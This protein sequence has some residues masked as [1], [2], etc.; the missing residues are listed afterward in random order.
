M[1]SAFF[2]AETLKFLRGLTRHNDRDWFEPRRE[3]Y[4]R[5]LRAPLLALIE[6]VNE[7]I[8]PFAPDH[9]RPPAKTAMRI[10]RD[11]RFSPD[12]RPYKRHVGA[13]WAERDTERTTGAGFYF[14]LG[15]TEAIF[16]AGVFM[17]S[18]PQLLAIRRWL[19]DHHEPY[20]KLVAA[21]LKPQRAGKTQSALPMLAEAEPHAL[22][23]VP[24]GFPADHPAA[25]LLRATRWGVHV[26]FSSETALQPGFTEEL[27][28][29]FRKASPVVLSLAAAIREGKQASG[30]GTDLLFARS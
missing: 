14:H 22:R 4:E 18:A 20:R 13:W 26:S 17:P 29:Y 2:T 16:A 11:T 27:L 24:R 15:A 19:L 1:P 25:D 6:A 8:A 23:R 12:K 5:A 7:G 3:I 10:Y 21:A 28:T 30:K 9:V